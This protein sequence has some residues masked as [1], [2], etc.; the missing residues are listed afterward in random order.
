V[1]AL[2]FV[3]D[4]LLAAGDDG[5]LRAWEAGSGAPRFERRLGQTL[6]LMTVSR[7]GRLVAVAGTDPRI[8][9]VGS[10][11]GMLL[12]TLQAATGQIGALTWVGETLVSGGAD[13]R[14]ALWERAA[15]ARP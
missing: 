4:R 15:A 6:R 5:V 13:G 8:E 11:D 12:R 3:G 14:V 2:A 10:A 7:D 9:I 1:R